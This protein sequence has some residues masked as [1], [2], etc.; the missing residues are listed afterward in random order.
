MA[1]RLTLLIIHVR[2]ERT[3]GSV[4]ED[5]R[6]LIYLLDTEQDPEYLL[7]LRHETTHMVWRSLYGEAPPLFQ[8]GLAEY[9]QQMSQAGADTESLLTGTPSLDT[10]PP[11]PDVA[12]TEA[13]WHAR[14]LYRVAGTFIWF[15]VETHGWG[16]LKALFQR[17]GYDDAAIVATFG[18]VYGVSLEDADREWRLFI[19]A[20]VGK[21]TT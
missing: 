20:K 3:F 2:S 4:G 12:P 9:V 5:A 11:L 18:E 8:E 21:G 15:L 14:G 13:F 17:S 10:A 1:S 16:K 6:L 19:G 7:R